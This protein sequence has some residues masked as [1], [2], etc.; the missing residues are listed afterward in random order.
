[1]VVAQEFVVSW[2]DPKD[3]EL[4]WMQDGMHAPDPITPLGELLGDFVTHG[5]AVTFEEYSVPIKFHM[6]VFNHWAYNS[7]TPLELLPDELERM[8]QEAEARIGA[9]LPELGDI[10]RKTYL[11]EIQSLLA[12][13]AA[14]DLGA[15]TIAELTAHWERTLEVGRRFF[16]IH[17]LILMPSMVA[18]SEFDELYRAFL[19]TSDPYESYRLLQGH[20][21]K[22]VE[23]GLAL[24]KLSRKASAL[25][26]I[27]RVLTEDV[28]GDVL[29]ALGDVAGGPGF[30]ADV[31]A[32][33]AEYGERGDKW[34]IAYPSWI[35][36][37]T[38]VLKNLKEYLG[39]ESHPAAE[40]EQAAAERELLI[41][42]ARE[43]LT[44]PEQLGAFD[45]LLKAGTDGIVITEDHGFWID[46]KGMHQVRMVCLEVG[47]RFADAGVVDSAED[48]FFLRPDEISETLRALPSID[49]RSLVAERKESFELAR[50]VQPPPML[51]TPAGEGPENP[52]ARSLG[53]FFG[54]PPPVS[55]SAGEVRGN[56]GSPGVVRGRARL[57]A[58][59]ADADRLDPGDVLV[60]I[61]TS[62]PWTPLF[63][64]ASAVV[65][66][67]GGIISH[68]AVV[69]R[70]YGIPAVVGCGDATVRIADG[71]SIEVDGNEGIVRLLS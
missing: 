26:E 64:F 50:Q 32:Y 12:V 62:P 39:Q 51:G 37:P 56:P 66:D 58:S 7:P 44:D 19:P 69:A 2:D 4:Q 59:I 17:F 27:R 42:Q 40:L 65:T 3:A 55:E 60:A 41:D 49:R 18:V 70:E 63:A 47:R 8:G 31:R 35:E 34:D 67:T 22:T 33:L 24:W 30:V 48:V 11:P 53:K 46:F 68:C 15:L 54:G 57:I 36:D 71:Q 21:N 6:K 38:P 20:L 1:M 9:V 28:S 5:F 43:R 13:L 52:I 25:P 14:V 61:T 16:E 29:R 45:F 23:T 10:W